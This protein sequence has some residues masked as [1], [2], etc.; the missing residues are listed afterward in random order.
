MRKKKERKG[1]ERKKWRNKVESD[2][3][4]RKEVGRMEGG[5]KAL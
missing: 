2:E 3:G 1:N 4:K 5:S